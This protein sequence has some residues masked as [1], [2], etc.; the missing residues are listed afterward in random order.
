MR[1]QVG[2]GL[3]LALLLFTG[4]AMAQEPLPQ[5]KNLK[6]TRIT[7]TGEDVPA[8]QQIVIQFNRPVVPLGRMER[9]ADEIPIEITPPL[10]C[11]W[12]WLNTSALAC[13]LSKKDALKA[14][15]RYKLIIQPGIKAEDGGTIASVHKHE[16]IT[17]RPQV[18]Y[19]WM[20]EWRGPEMPVFRITF[21]QPVT[22]TS[23]AKHVFI[24]YSPQD[25]SEE[26]DTAKRMA[27]AVEPV[28]NEA[29]I[30]SEAQRI[31]LVSPEKAL[32][33]NSH[34][35]LA[36]EPGLISS[37]GPEPSV[38][39]DARLSG[40]DTFP[41]FRFLG[42][43]CTTNEH[44][45]ILIK[46]DEPLHKQERCNPLQRVRLQFSSPV[47]RNHIKQEISLTPDPFSKEK[48]EE[49]E[50][51]THKR[52]I[53]MTHTR[54]KTYGAT[55]SYQL[56]A[57]EK[58]HL[59]NKAPEYGWLDRLK[60]IFITLPAT[61]IK[62]GFGRPLSKALNMHFLTDHR[63]P[64]Y[65]LDH[66]TAV[67]EKNVETHVPLIVTNLDRVDLDYNKLTAKQRDQQ[68]KATVSVPKAEDIAFAIPLKVRDLTGGSSGAI[69]G[70][71]SSTPAIK[72]Y[73]GERRLFAQVTPYQVHAKVGHFN[74]LVW[75]T[76][77]ATGKPVSGVNTQVTRGMIKTL[78]LSPDIIAQGLS[79]ADGMVI[80]PGTESL[81]PQLKYIGSYSSDKK[82]KM[83]LYLTKGDDMAL[84]PLDGRF[85][86]D[87][88]SVANDVYPYQRNRHGHMRAWG[89]T[90]QG[91]Y[92][93]GDTI[94]FK[95]YVRDQDN[96][97]LIPAPNKTYKLTVTDPTG[98]EVHKIEDITLSEFGGFHGEFKIP[99]KGAIGWYQFQLKADFHKG[100]WWPLRILV[101]DFTPAP[102]KVE[103]S[104]NGDQ[105]ETDD[106]V[107][108]TSL[109]KLHSGGPYTQAQAK[110]NAVIREK[111]FYP[112]H[113]VAKN[114][115]FDTFLDKPQVTVFQTESAL[116]DQ[117][118]NQTEF[119]IPKQEILY[120]ELLVETS[121]QDD[122]GKS[123]ANRAT[124]AFVGVD[125]LVGLR[126]TQWVYSANKPARFEY[127]VVDA[128]G[129]PVS[130]SPV[131]LTLERLIRKAARI[132]GAGNA[133]LKG[134]SEEWKSEGSCEAKTKREPGSCDITPRQAG[135]YRLTAEIHDTQNRVHKTQL[136]T[137]VVGSGYVLW[138]EGNDF[139]LKIIP[140][141]ES[142]RIGE[143]A[144][145]LI[146]NPFPGAKAL[147]TIERYGILKHWV[148]TLDNSTSVLEFPVEP[149][150]LPG[151]YLSAVVI[152]PRVDKPLGK[153]NVDLGKPAFRIGYVRV[154]V[155]DP[156][157]EMQVDIKTAEPV[158][159]PRE[160]VH[161][162]VKAQPRHPKGKGP[163]ELAVAVLDEAVFDMIQGGKKHFDPYEGFYRLDS[164]D[165]TNYNLITRLIGI[166]KFEKKGASPGGGG[167]SDV[168]MRSIFKFV[169][170]WN[171][172]IKTNENGEANFDFVLPDNLT[173][174]RILTLAMTPSDRMGLGQGNFKVN[175]P[176][177]ILPALP[178]QV[179][180]GDKFDA[181]FTIMN[182]TDKART[183][184]VKIQASGPI[185][186]AA[187][188]NSYKTSVK[189]EPFK[190]TQVWMPLQ[191][192]RKQTKFATE[193]LHFKVI[194]GDETDRDGLEHSIPVHTLVTFET[195]ADYGTT[196]AQHTETSIQ[197]P[198]QIRTDVGDL[199]VVLTPSVIG[200]V[201]GAF[202]Y[203]A[204]YPYSCWEQ[205]LSKGL[206]AS[207]YRNLKEYLPAE[208]EWKE[209]VEVTKSILEDAAD[210]QSPS[211][212]FTYYIPEDHYASPYLSAYTALA[213]N[214][215]RKSG[216]QIPSSVE[217]KLLTYLDGLLKRNVVPGYYS[218]GMTST[219]RAVA[220]AALAQHGKVQRSDLERYRK[221]VDAMS[222]FGRA[223]FLQAALKVPNAADI[224]QEVLEKILA[225]SNQSGGKFQFNEEL[226]DGF[227]RIL[228]TPLRSQCAI[229]SSLVAA[230]EKTI[231]FKLV[232]TLTQARGRKDHWENTQENVFCMNALTDYSRVF[233]NVTPDMTVDASLD[234]ENF[235]DASFYALN[236]E[237]V[238]LKRPLK[239]NDPGRKAKL[240][241]DRDGE[242]RL[243]YATRL[244]YAYLKPREERINSGIEIRREYSVR[245]NNKWVLLKDDQLKR[246]DVVRVDIF[247]DL[248]TAR[249]FVVVDDPVPGG[250]EPINR[251]LATASV[252]DAE[253]GDY[254]A[255]GGS[256]WFKFNDWS[257]YGVSRWSFYHQELRHN[258]VRFYSEYLAPGHYHLS[259]TA[260]AIATGNFGLFPIHAEEMYDPDIY[261]KGL[262]ATLQI[263][264][265]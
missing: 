2:I 193:A 178:N 242:G 226:D 172:S 62:D 209:S 259:Y 100:S 152:S 134:Y 46:P 84:I 93:A 233:E 166:Q 206:M 218:Q 4:T 119:K 168:A 32:P 241:L 82:E 6:I 132:K 199:S 143:T 3:S 157:N 208:L 111:N 177:Q 38:K 236:D 130:G 48:A 34:G 47:Q 65:V 159:K 58:Y 263:S 139:N 167:G 261:G 185:D 86:V 231:P 153:G 214:W 11:E 265:N 73:E 160:R 110:V 71:L 66:N 144:R 96:E 169:S 17:K 91:L 240:T 161:V 72:K 14:A 126:P 227:T 115:S 137:W 252:L 51:E 260:Q 211:G 20:Y 188:P 68:Q 180:L 262:P 105:F 140:E 60:S 151:F 42:I 27:V 256:Y 37:H 128:N 220:L 162:S 250:L 198:D 85:I 80:L 212:A 237:A 21:N 77:L 146:K 81:D 31:W 13:Q 135:S 64:D 26:G 44:K 89:T 50:S 251:D 249:Y 40:F 195:A 216:H 109:A 122:R 217:E 30:A 99:K 23:V 197:F 8:G 49:Q 103:T 150:F 59:T 117:G 163:I 181:G 254:Q 61:S 1:L 238:T 245:R 87:S 205:R 248:P 204:D 107:E 243:Y 176:T 113:P 22:K 142:Y 147:I 221:H 225:H 52:R 246:G 36:V 165:L 102:F 116:D 124:A 154:P 244:R 215:L 213:F 10:N 170:Y 123:V 97:S 148:Q 88:Y 201:A 120:G 174:W 141:K 194:A 247:I 239:A 136:H 29:K 179:S 175:R 15:H 54:K 45:D 63:L 94:Q 184:E 257:H 28:P 187:T 95:I 57:F 253:A 158:Y 232:R 258:A 207:H 186:A 145:Y 255:A 127:I 149:E 234:G 196:T 98:K 104:L 155:R 76:D 41:E 164:L 90:A 173:G 24:D 101:T 16:F 223:H 67:L 43:K 133:Y 74:T 224:A 191:T 264:N 83:F 114:F 39:E 12:R 230:K 75:I 112:R 131:K 9:K 25:S 5:S 171:P 33:P 35:I 138:D 79:D 182:R 118:R 229:L 189:L 78:E 18:R 190:R 70:N 106:K 129:T 202:R 19:A 69:Y 192:K 92:R 7:P 125:R 121:V 200:N 56:K 183:I 235:G 219:V 53:S 210:F 203:M 228:A 222:L 156:Y 108:V 55:I